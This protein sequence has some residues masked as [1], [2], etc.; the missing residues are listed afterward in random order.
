M[1][2]SDPGDLIIA[3]KVLCITGDTFR[4]LI[5]CDAGDLILTLGEPGNFT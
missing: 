3:W 2:S 4:C 5:P 1:T